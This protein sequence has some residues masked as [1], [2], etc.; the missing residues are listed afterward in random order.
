MLIKITVESNRKNQSDVGSR[1]LNTKYVTGLRTVDT[2]KSYLLYATAPRDR[3]EIPALI[4]T[5]EG[6]AV[7]KTAF[8]A[9]WYANYIDLPVF[10][11][12]N[13]NK[14]AVSY[15]FAIESIVYAK[16]YNAH[17]SWVYVQGSGVVTKYLVNY[18]LDQL[19]DL[20]D[21]GST[22]TSSTSSTSTSSTTT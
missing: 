2:T 13:T 11:E 15:T 9:T 12:D 18:N 7:Y 1:I 8:A 14:T 21:T 19:I 22:T 16:S 10:P 3:R 4:K 17:V 5:T 6:I 20:S